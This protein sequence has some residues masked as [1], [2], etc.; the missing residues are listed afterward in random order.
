MKPNN[1]FFQHHSMIYMRIFLSLFFLITSALSIANT[2]YPPK[3]QA[4]IAQSPYGYKAW[5]KLL[6]EYKKTSIERYEAACFLIANMPLH[7]Q[8]YVIEQVDTALLQWLN[9]ADTHYYALVQQRSDTALFNPDFNDNILAKA[10]QAYRKA[11]EDK[12]FMPPILKFGNFTDIEVLSPDFIKQ[13]IDHAFAVRARNPFAKYLSF[14]DFLNYI[15][16][17]RAMEDNPIE[18]ALTYASVYEKYLHTDTTP[19]IHN[20]IWRYNLTAKRLRYW[21]GTYPFEQPAGACELWFLGSEDCANTVDRAALHLRACGIP[22]AVEYN[23]AYKIWEGRHYHLSTPTAKG[24]ETFNPEESLPEYRHKGFINTLNVYRIQFAQQANAPF[25]L[26]SEGEPLPDDLSSPFIV[27]VTDNVAS[28]VKLTLPFTPN[29]PHRLAYLASFRTSDYGLQPVTWGIID[30]HTQTITFEHVVPNH[31]YYPIYLDEDGETLSFA[32]PFYIST[33][34][35]K[36]GYSLREYKANRKKTLVGH[37][38][39]TYPEAAEMKEAAQRAIGTFVIAS[40]DEK[41]EQADTIGRILKVANTTW[42]DLPLR[43]KRPYRFY[44]VCGSPEHP[45]VYLGEIAFLSDQDTTTYTT[46]APYNDRLTPQENAK[47]KQLWDAPLE[48]STWKAEYDGQ[49]QTAP[50]RWPDVTLRLPTP[51]IVNRLRY[52]AKHA[53]HTIEKG[54]TYELFEWSDGYWKR[55]LTSVATQN[56]LNCPSLYE[57]QLYWLKKQQKAEDSQPF[58]IDA[59]GQQH[60]PLAPH[61]GIE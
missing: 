39:R 21:G 31:L 44:R 42:E 35:S 41:F 6:D 16:P 56:H 53:G 28:T 2:R 36:Q 19:H 30:K 25:T 22:V 17:Y 26:R 50:D 7:Q 54:R 48:Q 33:D 58:F 11:T 27:D 15:L 20:V 61:T 1:T 51:K 52:M 13:H 5:S 34:S 49:P 55:V 29:T 47:W 38:E 14:Q 40:D 3:V 24:W 18:T 4:A 32:N 57:G 10:D 46:A 59:K 9:H 23:I 60:F 12:T 45:N 8:R 43:T 37:I